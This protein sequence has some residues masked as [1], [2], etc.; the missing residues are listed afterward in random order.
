MKKELKEK[1][2]YIVPLFLYDKHYR[3]LCF[4]C[5]KSIP[6]FFDTNT[7]SHYTLG[8][9]TLAR[10]AFM[11]ILLAMPFWTVF[12]ALDYPIGEGESILTQKNSDVVWSKIT[13]SED[14]LRD[15]SEEIAK[16]LWDSS[17]EEKI[18]YSEIKDTSEAWTE[19]SR[20]RKWIINWT[21]WI[22]W[23]AALIYLLIHWLM[24]LTAWAD[25]EKL[26]KWQSWIRYALIAIF[27]IAVAWF[28]VSIIFR[29]I[30]LLTTP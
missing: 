15:W 28:M 22:A 7:L 2:I 25:E 12:S 3:I 20:T 30:W 17:W 6:I 24:A 4:Y 1:Y 9:K 29:L 5:F 26:K 8:M 27:G 11:A 19:V 16:W 21:L 14:V 18:F 13:D 23:L 10:I